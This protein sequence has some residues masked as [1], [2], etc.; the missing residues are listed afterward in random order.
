MSDLNVLSKARA[1]FASV[2]LL[3]A[4]AAI[5]AVAN[6]QD[7]Q[8]R[9]DR[10]M[11]GKVIL[12]PPTLRSLAVEWP[13]TGDDNRNASVQ[14]EYRE[15]GAAAWR[16][17]LPLFRLQH[18]RVLPEMGLSPEDAQFDYTAPNLFTGSLFDLKPGGA[19]EIRLTARDP[20]G[21]AGVVR[22]VI[23][24]QTRPIPKPATDGR[25]FHVYPAGYA[26]P[27]QQPAFEGLL[28]A[29]NTGAEHADWNHVYNPRVRPGDTIL[30]HAGVYKGDRLEYGNY[31]IGGL[32]PGRP[33]PGVGGPGYGIPFDGT[34]LL[35]G[36]G[37]AERPITIKAAGDG[38]V[39][40]DGAGAHELFNVMGAEHNIFDGINI[41]NVDIAF[42]AGLKRIGGA[43]GLTIVHSRIEDVG[44]A[45][46]SDYEGSRDFYIADNTIVGRANKDRLIGWNAGPVWKDVPGWP[47]PL[48]SFRAIDLYGPGH[49]VE[50]N[51]IDRFHDGV[52]LS[53]YGEP[54]TLGDMTYPGDRARLG[55]DPRYAPGPNSVDIMNNDISNIGDV[56]VE[57]DGGARNIRVL[58]NRCFNVAGAQALRSQPSFGGP[59]YFI[60]NV[61]Y[62]VV[63][64]GGGPA[65]D[66]SGMVFYNNT[67]FG[68]GGFG[69]RGANLQLRNNLFVGTGR[70]TPVIAMSTFTNYSSSDYNGFA[71]AHGN[72]APFSW[73]SP[74]FAVVTAYEAP[75][76][77]TRNFASLEPYQAATGQDA[78]SR[79]IDIDIFRSATAPPEADPSRLYRPD[80]IDLQLRAGSSAVDAGAQL[81]GVTDGMT[82][83]APDL[84]AYELGSPPPH[85]GPRP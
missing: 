17:G 34:Y 56:C 51:R 49:V 57:P 24:A 4:V 5:P 46:I 40:F 69:G 84:G 3:L 7:G 53:T 78:H 41:R 45:V 19:Y 10:L 55:F 58:Y 65:A 31:S 67:I 77:V 66:G 1:R 73:S 48:T 54:D 27:K 70:A 83:A 42:R 85:Y 68:L 25:V 2:V 32:A 23:A 64:A 63:G 62:H 12:E 8:P 50:F 82:G 44:S 37:T 36:K 35:Q 74:D 26:G 21:V 22:Q 39:W 61:V 72:A 15:K 6:A 33:G 28:K 30:V 20:D 13:I 75:K 18:E 43:K 52:T 38:E 76:L 80:D 79:L 29:Y 47:A 81:P 11:L 59:H 9:R 14:V 71:F 16:E 60:R